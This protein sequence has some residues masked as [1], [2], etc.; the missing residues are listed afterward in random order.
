MKKEERLK[1]RYTVRDCSK[2]HYTSA[3]DAHRSMRSILDRIAR[4][5]NINE[6]P[7]EHHV[8]PPD[9]E[10]VND[11]ET[12]TEEVLDIVDAQRIADRV[13]EKI[14]KYEKDK[15]DADKAKADADFNAKVEEE[16]AKRLQQHNNS[17]V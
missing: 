14:A 2:Q 9:G 15:A 4:G 10:D 13:A 1:R 12:G 7:K 16:L 8:L 5:Q 17:S 6:M 3:P 11:F